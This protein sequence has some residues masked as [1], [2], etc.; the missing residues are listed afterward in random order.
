MS[1]FT[2]KKILVTHNGVFHADDIFSAAALSIL[3]N[4]DI[5]VIRTRDPKIISEADFVFDVGGEYDPDRNRFDH[6]Q[7]G[8]AGARTDKSKI[9][10]AAFGL[11][12]KTYGEK[13]CGGKEIAEKI[14]SHLVQ[15]VDA[16]DNGINLCELKG[17]VVPYFLQ[18]IIFMF[19]P[20]F[21]EE[22]DYDTPFLELVAFAKKILQ[23]EIIKTRDAFSAESVVKEAYNNATDKRII[24][25]DGCY[26]WEETLGKY[27]EPLY[28]VYPKTDIWRVKCVPKEMYSFENRKP[29]PE[30]WAGKRDQELTQ[31]TGVP[32]ATFCHNGR[33]MCVSKSKDGALALAQKA[34][35]G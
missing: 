4:G 27:P 5:K 19:R 16:N 26:P 11:V 13:I 18:D 2:K 30:V 28:V 8:G 22:P 33:F 1:F 34:L 6:H 15:A 9:P 12:W 24:T 29:L 35:I 23:R 17:E 7:P 10:Y 3:L 21:K 31:I 20:S 32:D 14:E 25:L